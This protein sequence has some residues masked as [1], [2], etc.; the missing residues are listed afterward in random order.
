MYIILETE[1][2]TWTFVWK[3]ASNR[4]MKGVINNTKANV[5]T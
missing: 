4:M 2:Y 1:S 3:W 5:S